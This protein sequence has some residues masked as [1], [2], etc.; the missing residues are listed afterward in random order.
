MT[1]Y[2]GKM[3]ASKLE[4]TRDGDLMY[5]SGTLFA[6]GTYQGI[7]GQKVRYSPS[8]TPM[9]VGTGKG[10]PIIYKHTEK[11]GQEKD[12]VVGFTS[13][14]IDDNGEAKYTGYIYNPEVF[15]FIEDQTFN[16]VSPELEIDGSYDSGD[17][18]VT[19]ESVGLS[20]L[21]LTNHARKGIDSASIDSH[22][23]IHISLEKKDVKDM[24][25]EFNK[26]WEGLPDTTRLELARKYLEAKGLKV[27]DK[28]PAPIVDTKALEGLTKRLDEQAGELAYFQNR[29]I[30]ELE[31]EVKKLDPE[32]DSKVFLE[33][34]ASFGTKKARLEQHI[35]FLN[36]LVPRI[37]LELSGSSPSQSTSELKEKQKVALEMYGDKAKEFA[38]DLFKEVK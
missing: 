26:Q 38:P 9:V 19:A 27:Y 32:F 6:P 28:E 21:A 37:K 25:D 13:T 14:V 31:S 12:L 7:D 34:A 4:T 10:K 1:H 29:E 11:D 15:P 2:L 36:R 20:S 23:M 18:T 33:G 16:A 17:N 3:L 8:M 30:V 5:V 22:K 24:G 35:T